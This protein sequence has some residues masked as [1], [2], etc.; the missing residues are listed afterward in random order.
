MS[1]CTLS[2]QIYFST[3]G[4]LGFLPLPYVQTGDDPVYGFLLYRDN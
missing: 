2:G 3:K 1:A 4:D